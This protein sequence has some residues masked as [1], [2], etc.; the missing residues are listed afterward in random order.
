VKNIFLNVLKISLAAGLIFYLVRNNHIDIQG[1]LESLW[2]PQLLLY[3][4]INLVLYVIMTK[5]LQLILRLSSVQCDYPS[6]LKFN[7]IGAFFNFALPGSV[8]GDV[9][10]GVYIAKHAGATKARAL[11]AALLDRTVALYT[12][13]LGGCL[14]VFLPEKLWLDSYYLDFLLTLMIAAFVIWTLTVFISARVIAKRYSDHSRKSEGRVA[15]YLHEFALGAQNFLR[16]PKQLFLIL[17]LSLLGQVLYVWMFMM[18]ADQ[19]TGSHLVGYWTH[20]FVQSVGLMLV[21]IP[22]SPAGIGVG[23]AVFHFLYGEILGNTSSLGAT[24]ISVVQILNLIMGLIGT[25]FFI[26]SRHKR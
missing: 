10:K 23:Q 16:S 3:V 24:A 11:F 26:T 5:R 6:L 8:S 4:A 7:F 20:F 25:Y 17:F 22:I 13:I 1:L 18:I 14:V 9:V 12:F 19:L 2:G 15:R 21:A